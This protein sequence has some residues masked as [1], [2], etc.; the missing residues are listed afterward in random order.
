MESESPSPVA[1]QTLESSGCAT[2]DPGGHGRGAPAWDGVESKRIHV[3][4]ETAGA[5]DTRYDDE[6]FARNPQ[7]GKNGLYRRQNGVVSRSRGTSGLPDRSES[8]S[9]L[10]LELWRSY[11]LSL[12]PIS[13]GTDFSVAENF[14]N[15]G[16]EFG[17][18]ERLPLDFVVA[19]GVHQ[20]LCSEESWRAGPYSFPAPGSLP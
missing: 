20:I 15:F 7:F 16:F 5:A 10:E 14:L 18:F 2:F 11:S 3:I 6:F 9:W 13:P 17:L 8:L 19:L 1:T 4:R 12:S